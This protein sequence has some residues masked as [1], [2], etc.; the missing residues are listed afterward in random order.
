MNVFTPGPLPLDHVAVAVSSIAEA[1]GLFQLLSGH[2]GSEVEVLEGQGVRT[3][4]CGA[5]EL[6][7]PLHP[8]TPVGRFLA[9]RGP[10]LHHIAYRTPDLEAELR[11]LE[12]EGIELLDSQPRAG[13]RGHRIAVLHPR[14]TG[15][16]LI[17]LV[18]SDDAHAA[19]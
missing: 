12:K 1:A 15:G 5:V 14:S 17:E 10:G 3:S 9:R 19:E 13:A 4:F 16:V 2:A 18:E 11:R 8:D 6:L 7:E